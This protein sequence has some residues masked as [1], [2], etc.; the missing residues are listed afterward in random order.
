[1][2]F[3]VVRGNRCWARSP[4]KNRGPMDPLTLSLPVHTD[5]LGPIGVAVPP[6]EQRERARLR[7]IHVF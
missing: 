4:K 6:G 5:P 1:M 2:Y 3:W 7:K